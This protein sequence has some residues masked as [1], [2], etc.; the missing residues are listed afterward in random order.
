[1]Q[2]DFNFDHGALPESS[3]IPENWLDVWPALNP[4]NLGHT[5]DPDSNAYARASDP[6]SRPSRID[7]VLVKSVHWLPRYHPCPPACLRP[8]C[9]PPCAAVLLC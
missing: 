8:A 9:A 5:W 7:R 6:Q 2:G 4:E 1:M 3:H